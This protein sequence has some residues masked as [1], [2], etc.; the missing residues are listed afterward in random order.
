MD[1]GV[2]RSRIGPIPTRPTRRWLAYQYVAVRWP[3]QLTALMHSMSREASMRRCA[4]C[5]VA[6]PPDH[7]AST[8]DRMSASIEVKMRRRRIRLLTAFCDQ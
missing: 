8:D 3:L 5:A 4:V 7:A 6:L 1:H 2:L